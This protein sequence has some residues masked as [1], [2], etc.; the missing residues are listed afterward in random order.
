VNIIARKTFATTVEEDLQ[1]RFKEICKMKE[2][3]INEAL[4]ALMQ[5]FIN[6]SIE[7]DV[8]TIYTVKSKNSST[9]K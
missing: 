8:Q 6:G 1:N 2:I 7:I 9:E 4:E 3:K 5:A